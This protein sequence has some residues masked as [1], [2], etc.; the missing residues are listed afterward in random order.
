MESNL[1]LIWNY[2]FSSCGKIAFERGSLATVRGACRRQSPL[3]RCNER[4]SCQSSVDI[5]FCI[6]NYENRRIFV[7][8]VPRGPP[9]GARRK[10]G[11]ERDIHQTIVKLADRVK[12]ETHA[13][14]IS[15]TTYHLKDEWMACKVFLRSHYWVDLISLCCSHCPAHASK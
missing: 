3:K 10:E 2:L 8:R 15:W 4:S 13:V 11:Q 9:C 1:W 5:N 14:S 6:V 12:E 7:T